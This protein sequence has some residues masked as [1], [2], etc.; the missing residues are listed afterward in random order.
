MA[1]AFLENGTGEWEA[2]SLAATTR[3]DMKQPIAAQRAAAT[4]H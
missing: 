2:L 1:L 4:F 3:R